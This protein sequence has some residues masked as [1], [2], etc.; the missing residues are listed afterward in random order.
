MEEKYIVTLY[1]KIQLN[2]NVIVFRRIGTIDN[3]QI[4]SNDEFQEITYYDNEGKRVIVECMTN[5]YTFV[6]DDIY[7]YGFPVTL[8]TLKEI[9]PQKRI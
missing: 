4:D 5:P 8:S 6:S 1:Q 9:Y 3:V 2:E 7:C